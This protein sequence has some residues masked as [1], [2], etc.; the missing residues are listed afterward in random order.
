MWSGLPISRNPTAQQ[1]NILRKETLCRCEVFG[2]GRHLLV[3]LHLFVEPVKVTDDDTVHYVNVSGSS[4]CAQLVTFILKERRK[5]G[6]HGWMYGCQR[7]S[8]R[9]ELTH[10]VC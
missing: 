6:G 7:S 3:S 8:D 10:R 1:L 4:R 5:V 9:D 2:C